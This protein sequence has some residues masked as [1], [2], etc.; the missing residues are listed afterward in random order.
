M[1]SITAQYGCGCEL[2]ERC[3]AGCAQHSRAQGKD[4]KSILRRGQG[5][6]VSWS[7][8]KARVKMG[9]NETDI[10]IAKLVLC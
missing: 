9:E 3:E 6:P 4:G 1:K 7:R 5:R 8:A 2:G 10:G